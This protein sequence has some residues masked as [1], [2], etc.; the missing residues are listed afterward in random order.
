MLLWH[1]EAFCTQPCWWADGGC[2]ASG[3]PPGS[4]AES[5]TGPRSQVEWDATAH[6]MPYLTF[7]HNWLMKIGAPMPPVLQ[8]TVLAAPVDVRI[9]H[10]LLRANEERHET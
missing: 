3:G 6:V 2:F 4:G 1:G 8:P 7:L 9:D 10:Q 5:S